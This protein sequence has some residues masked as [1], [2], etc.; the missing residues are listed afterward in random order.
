MPL[1]SAPATSG[2]QGMCT[3]TGLNIGIPLYIYV[4]PSKQVTQHNFDRLY[5]FYPGFVFI[6]LDIPGKPVYLHIRL[7][8]YLFGLFHWGVCRMSKLGAMSERKSRKID[9]ILW[10]MRAM[11]CFVPFL[12]WAYARVPTAPG[13]IH[14]TEI[15]RN[16]TSCW[17]SNSDENFGTFISWHCV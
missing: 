11:S 7:M 1:N 14:C 12:L 15:L 9:R 4:H 2:V 3:W 10:E 8:P 5:F 16:K 6:K 17:I 13:P